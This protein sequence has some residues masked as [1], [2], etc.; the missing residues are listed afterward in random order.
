MASAFGVE[1]LGS[2]WHHRADESLGLVDVEIVEMRE[3]DLR[4]G[5]LPDLNFVGPTKLSLVAGLHSYTKLPKTLGLSTVMTEKLELY[6]VRGAR[7]VDLKLIDTL[8]LGFT[9]FVDVNL[10]GALVDPLER[11]TGIEIEEQVV[12]GAFG[13]LGSRLLNGV[14]D[15]ALANLFALSCAR[16]RC[17]LFLFFLK[18]GQ[19]LCSHDLVFINDALLLS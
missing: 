8:A 3:I 4:L 16:C 13:L 11:L 18:S 9:K 10:V 12:L 7:V 2:C 6:L 14:V 15:G 1:I 19:L 17:R 5:K